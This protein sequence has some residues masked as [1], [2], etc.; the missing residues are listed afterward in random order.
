MP[1]YK[2]HWKEDL[3]KYRPVSL[4]LVLVKVMEQII[5]SATTWHEQ[6]SHQAQS[7]LISLI[8]FYDKMTRLVDEGKAVDVVSLDF[9]KAFDTVFHSILLEK[10]ECTL[11]KFAGDTKL[12]RSVNLLERRKGLQRDLNKL[13]Q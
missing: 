9:G 12:G 4:I 3:E 8:S 11:S 7:S 5:L 13:D 2:K 10:L 1:I 6:S